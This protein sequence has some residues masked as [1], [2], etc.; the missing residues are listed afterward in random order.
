MPS[1]RDVL[2]FLSRGELLAVVDRFEL[3]VADRRV[4]DQLLEAIAPSKKTSVDE[5]LADCGRDRLK[6]LC[7]ALGFDDGGKET[8]ALVDSLVGRKSAAETAPT[9]QSNRVRCGRDA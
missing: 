7:R 4:K 5:A 9:S 1:K 2:S 3:P 8:G 6:E